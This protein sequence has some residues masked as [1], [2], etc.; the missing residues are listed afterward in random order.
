MCGGKASPNPD[1][2]QDIHVV[3]GDNT[4]EMLGKNW[5]YASQSYTFST[6]SPNTWCFVNGEAG[7]YGSNIGNKTLLKA[8]VKAGV[9]Y[10]VSCTTKC[11]TGSLYGLQLVN[12]TE[13]NFGSL[14]TSD[15]NH[16]LTFTPQKDSVAIIRVYLNSSTTVT[17]SNIQC[18][19]N[20]TATP[21]K[22][23]TEQE[24]LLSLGSL[25][26]AKIGDYTDRIF[27][28][29]QGD[30]IYD[31]LDNTTK[32]SL[33]IGS[34]YKQGNIRKVTLNGTE[35]WSTTSLDRKSVV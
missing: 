17:I 2:P 20:S 6:P 34:W 28:A 22:P 25:E 13:A 4:V 5:Y 16:V 11:S 26:L 14:G 33:T 9:T 18:E 12:G 27:K 7:A 23:Y 31:S 32:A 29:V 3:T 24:Q 19:I 1:Y 8:P 10:T 35:D 15:G 30:S 21:Y